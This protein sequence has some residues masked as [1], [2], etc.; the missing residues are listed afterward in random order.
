M[1][2]GDNDEAKSPMHQDQQ[3]HN[4]FNSKRPRLR[5]NFIT[6]IQR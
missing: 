1:T 2:E 3:V 6:N 4:T 5:H